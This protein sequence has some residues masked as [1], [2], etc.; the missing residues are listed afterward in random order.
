MYKFLL[1]LALCTLVPFFTAA[2]SEAALPQYDQTQLDVKEI[3][4]EDL[5]TYRKDPKFDYE[6]KKSENNWWNRFTSWLLYQLS[7]FFEWVFGAEKAVGFLAVFLRVVPYVL[8]GVLIF[9]LVKFFLKVN[10]RALIY[11]KKNTAVVSLSEDEHII[12][13]GDIEQLIQKALKNKDYRLAIRYYYLFILQLMSEKQLIAWE[14]QK[15]NDDYLKELKTKE[16]QSPFSRTTRLYDHIW[17][18]GFALDEIK[19]QKAEHAFSSL[20]KTLKEDV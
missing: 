10:S 3:S 11:S 18:G 13:N 7:Q 17:Y 12:K 8:L 20:H 19:Y 14:L 4:E 5:T 16:L 1:V 2:Q 9:L 15:T 6:I